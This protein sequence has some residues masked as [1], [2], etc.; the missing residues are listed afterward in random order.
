MTRRGPVVLLLPIL[1]AGAVVI[2]Q[3]DDAGSRRARADAADSEVERSRAMA[4]AAPDDAFSSTWFCAGGATSGDDENSHVVVV[5]NPTDEV[6][7]GS[8]TAVP[9]RGR[10]RTD[11]LRVPAHDRLVVDLAGLAQA[12]LVAATLEFAGGEV[13]VE[14]QVSGPTGVDVAPCA[15]SGSDTWYFAA[16]ATTR[17]ADE[18]L[19]L[20]NPFADDAS[21][22]ISFATADG[23]RVPAA[24][25]GI[26]VPAR[27]VVATRVTPV[28]T[29][30][31][32]VSTSIVARSGRVVAERIQTYDGRGASTT[33]QG[34]ADEP[35]RP[36]GLTITPGVPRPATAWMFPVGVKD[37]GVHERYVVYNPSNREADVDVVVTLDDPER[38]GE[39]DPFQLPLPPRSFGV[40]DLDAEDRVPTKVGHAAVVVARNG[41]PVVAERLLAATEPS[42]TTDTAASPGSTLAARRWVFAVGG[43]VDARQQTSI[44]LQNPG[45]GDVVVRIAL[46]DRGGQSVSDGFG[47]ITLGAF[48]HATVDLAETV[49]DA[50]FSLLVT[51]DGPV[52]SERLV[53]RRGTS[54]S[55]AVGVPLTDGLVAVGPAAAGG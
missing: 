29:V 20:F 51:A 27:S 5:A 35:Y 12:P 4:V 33:E 36:E 52:A 13:A 32:Q 6:V 28:V 46:L 19:V 44:A 26:Q 38:N 30:R 48:G 37:D 34:A 54:L 24:F 22:D 14:H 7:D 43:T 8:V 39:I 18:T 53:G 10:S 45:P 42:T 21:L 55:T 2:D 23:R 16:G 40:V 15:T 31:D 50:A 3:R 1:I 9:S 47:P 49:E 11:P 41:V 25:Q 17:D